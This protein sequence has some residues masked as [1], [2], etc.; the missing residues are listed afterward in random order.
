[1]T[2]TREQAADLDRYLT[3]EPP[4]SPM[5]CPECECDSEDCKDPETDEG[6]WITYEER[7]RGRHEDDAYDAYIDAQAERDA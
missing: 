6:E 3:R 1:M 2:F 7:D 5:W 4:D